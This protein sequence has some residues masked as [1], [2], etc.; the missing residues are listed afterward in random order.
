[1]LVN[2]VKLIGGELR[3]LRLTMTKEEPHFKNIQNLKSIYSPKVQ[4]DEILMD[5]DLL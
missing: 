3:W 1:M 4:I 5:F 2:K